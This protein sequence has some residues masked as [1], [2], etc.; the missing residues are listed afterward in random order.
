MKMSVPAYDHDANWQARAK[1]HIALG[2]E[3]QGGTNLDRMSNY[4]YAVPLTA[5][6]KC[7]DKFFE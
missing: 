1:V 4:Q 5:Y 6:V 2:E 7:I 3:D